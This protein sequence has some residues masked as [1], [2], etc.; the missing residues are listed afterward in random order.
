MAQRHH[1]IVS[2]DDVMGGEPRIAGRRI[3]VRQ[4]AELVESDGLDAEAVADRYDLDVADVYRALTYYHDNPAEMARVERT[5]A[6]EERAALET[7]AVRR[8]DL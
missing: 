8:S 2:D 1:R 7:E 4:I 5:R 3:A 6:E